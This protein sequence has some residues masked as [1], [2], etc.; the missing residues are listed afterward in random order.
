[1]PSEV[2]RRWVSE[3]HAPSSTR[4]PL[5]ARVATIDVPT[6]RA[7]QDH[8]AP[9]IQR[10]SRICRPVTTGTAAVA[11]G[12]ARTARRSAPAWNSPSRWMRS[13]CS[14]RSVPSPGDR[15][16]CR[17]QSTEG[18]WRFDSRTGSSHLGPQIAK[19]GGRAGC[20]RRRQPTGVAPQRTPPQQVRDDEREEQHHRAAQAASMN[21]GAMASR[22]STGGR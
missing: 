18:C 11:E 12:V 5:R 9:V 2:L 16:A 20:S 19:S 13:C 21:A 8:A 10:T 6:A 15:G 17:R 7:Q 4:L 14:R 1:M 22:R 3:S